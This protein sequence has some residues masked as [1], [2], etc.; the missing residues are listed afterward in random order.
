MQ[1]FLEG[2]ANDYFGK[3]LSGARLIVRPHREATFV[4]AENILIGNVALMGATSGEVFLNGRAGERFAVRNSGATAVVEGV[5]DHGCEYMT[6]GLVLVLGAVGRNFAAGMTGGVAFAYDPT[7]VFGD[8]CSTADVEIEVPNATELA[9]IQA[10]ISRHLAYTDSRLVA[11]F[12]W[13]IGVTIR[14]FS[15]SN[16]P[17]IQSGFVEKEWKTSGKERKSEWDK[18]YK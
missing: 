1:F 8:Q 3:G 13:K 9:Q 2:E 18:R 5:G 10:L 16:A 12:P 6:G 7:A 14:H 11:E 17:R 15:E 4:A